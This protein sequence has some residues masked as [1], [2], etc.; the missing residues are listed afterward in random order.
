MADLGGKRALVTGATGGI[1]LWTALGLMRQGAQ[2][3]IAGRSAPRLASSAAWLAQQ[4]GR[5]PPRTELADFA[6]LAAVQALAERVAGDPLD[7]LVNNAGLITKSREVSRDGYEMIF[8]VNHLA[9]FVLTRALLP[10]L[11]RAPSARIVT[12]ASIAHERGR[13][14]WDDLM[15]QRNWSPLRAYAQSKLANILFTLSLSR[16]LAGSSVTA[17]AVHPGVVGTGFGQV[18]GV[19]GLAW[20]LASPFLLSPEKGARTTLHVAT[21]PELAGASGGYF[22]RSRPTEPRPQARDTAAAERLWA[23]SE[24]LTAKVLA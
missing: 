18:G 4:S 22:A 12:V 5:S 1:G 10:A 15:M 21:A 8:A 2:V 17:N 3:T 6:S 20:S 13:M 14:H 23:E 9:P 7:V 11:H 19:F 16:R 24:R